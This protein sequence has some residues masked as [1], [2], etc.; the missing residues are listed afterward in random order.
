[1]AWAIHVRTYESRH[2]TSRGSL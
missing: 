2:V 1:M